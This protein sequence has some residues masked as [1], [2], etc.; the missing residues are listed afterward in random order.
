MSLVLILFR[1]CK[2]DPSGIQKG[3][4]K[5]TLIHAVN[6]FFLGFANGGTSIQWNIDL[7]EP[8]TVVGDE[9]LNNAHALDKNSH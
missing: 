5:D 3:L 9:Y 2:A 4:F 7:K 6:A 8:T 1:V